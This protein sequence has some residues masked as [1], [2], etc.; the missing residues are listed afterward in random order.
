MNLQRLLQLLSRRSHGFVLPDGA[1]QFAGVLPGHRFA[2]TVALE[3]LVSA[4]PLRVVRIASF[5]RHSPGT[6]LLC[7][8]RQFLPDLVGMPPR[9]K[10]CAVLV[11][12][13]G[14]HDRGCTTVENAPQLQLAVAQPFVSQIALTVKQQIKGHEAWS[15]AA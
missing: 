14:K 2:V 15:T 10:L 4:H 7:A 11:D 12:V 13:I 6:V 5:P 1:R 9:I 8:S 3:Q